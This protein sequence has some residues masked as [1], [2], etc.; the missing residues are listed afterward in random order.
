MSLEEARQI[1]NLPDQ[2][3]GVHVRELASGLYGSFT[4]T[5][6]EPC[7]R[8]LEIAKALERVNQEINDDI[9]TSIIQQI[10]STATQVTVSMPM[11]DP[12]GLKNIGN[13]CY[14]NSLLQLLNTIRPIREFANLVREDEAAREHTWGDDVIM[15]GGPKR[16][17]DQAS[18]G[19]L[20]PL[21]TRC[22][23]DY[24][25]YSGTGIRQAL[26]TTGCVERKFRDY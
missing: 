10:R 25:S 20:R 5:H 23:T 12:R 3:P 14:L 18:K 9:L 24:D 22:K 15:D 2:P 26:P 6:K 8:Q 16:N 21:L 19:I 13:T 4:E 11:G 7:A 17:A 1:L